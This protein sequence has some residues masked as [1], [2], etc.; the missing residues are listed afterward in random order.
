MFQSACCKLRVWRETHV[1]NIKRSTDEYLERG[2]K[3]AALPAHATLR[4]RRP[5]RGA[6]RGANRSDR[7]L[8]TLR[9]APQFS[10]VTGRQADLEHHVVR[11]DVSLDAGH[12]AATF[13]LLP[14]R[15]PGE[16][17]ERPKVP[18]C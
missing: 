13:A 9:K 8:P 11:G 1:N 17:T 5:N 7:R 2:S 12:A 16:V 6:S 10:L 15:A 3:L 18:A 14:Q 4:Q